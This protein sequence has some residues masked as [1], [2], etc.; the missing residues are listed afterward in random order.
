VYDTSPDC[1]TAVKD[2]K[3]C[4]NAKTHLSFEISEGRVL[5]LAVTGIMINGCYEAYTPLAPIYNKASAS[6]SGT[7]PSKPQGMQIYTSQAIW[8]A[9]KAK[10]PN[11]R[12]PSIPPRLVRQ[13]Q[14]KPQH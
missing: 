14:V 1:L 10:P 4:A 11:P 2:V 5:Q 7:F 3:D 13:L 12:S 6:S 8:Y 9:S